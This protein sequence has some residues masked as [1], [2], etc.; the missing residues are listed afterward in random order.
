MTIDVGML[1]LDRFER[2]RLMGSRYGMS[3]LA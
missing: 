3:V 1:G 2:N